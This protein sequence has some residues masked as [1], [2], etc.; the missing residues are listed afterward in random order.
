MS[1]SKTSYEHLNIRVDKRTLL[2]LYFLRL[3]RHEP[4]CLKCCYSFCLFS[5]FLPYI[6]PLGVLSMLFSQL[7][8]F[9]V[10]G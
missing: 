1:L 2:H 6:Y 9:D 5:L 4:K 3:E 7:V 8:L 10:N